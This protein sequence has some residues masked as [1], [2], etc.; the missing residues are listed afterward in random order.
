MFEDHFDGGALDT[1]VWV[2][3]YLPMWS[4]RAASA[5]TYELRDSEL[6]LSI[7][8]GQGLWCP[9]EHPPLRVS[10]IQSGVWSGAVGSTRGQQPFR[11]GLVVREFQPEQRGLTPLHGR[12]EVRARMEL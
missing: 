12:I 11:E 7:P 10:G 8:P 9:D 3:S 4:S 2:P 1:A 5:A 6:R